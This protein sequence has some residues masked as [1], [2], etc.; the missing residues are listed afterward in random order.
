VIVTHD[1]HIAAHT[2]RT[3]ELRDGRI[4]TETTNGRHMP[5]GMKL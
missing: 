5:E 4:E 3:V 2:Q 1:A